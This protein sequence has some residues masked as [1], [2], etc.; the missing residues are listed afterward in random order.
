MYYIFYFV[1]WACWRQISAPSR[2]QLFFCSEET[3][4]EKVTVVVKRNKYCWRYTNNFHSYI[5]I[6][7]YILRSPGYI[8]VSPRGLHGAGGPP[9]AQQTA[10]GP[11]AAAVAPTVRAAPSLQASRY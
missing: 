8:C 7:I 10:Q 9:R 5:Y 4:L 6:Y 2:P 11:T 3:R 1:V